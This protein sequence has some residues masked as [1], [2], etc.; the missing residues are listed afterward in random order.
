MEFVRRLGKTPQERGSLTNTT[1]PDVFEL[2]DGSFA[3]VGTDQT[4]MLD[5]KLPPGAARAADERIVVV[6]RE[7]LVCAKAD[8][9]EA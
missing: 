4:E 7:V 9:P 1:C 5:G 8:I 2:S 6:P 3:I